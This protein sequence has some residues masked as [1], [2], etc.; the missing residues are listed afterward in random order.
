MYHS[1]K[2]FK[3]TIISL[4]ILALSVG[5]AYA[6]APKGPY[7]SYEPGEVVRSGELS[8]IGPPWNWR[9]TFRF[10][11]TETDIRLGGYLKADFIYDMDNDMGEV[12]N[13][14]LA[15]VTPRETDGKF[16]AHA[17]ESRINIGTSTATD[18]GQL[19]T[20]FESHFLGRPGLGEGE[21]NQ[22]R[23]AYMEL[24][25]V[26]AG[27]TWSNVMSFIGSP[28]IVKL[29]SPTGGTFRRT[30]Q[31]RYSMKPAKSHQLTLSLEDHDVKLVNAS[32][33]PTPRD[34]IGIDG[35]SSAPA[36]TARYE[37]GRRFA[38][39]GMVRE[40]DVESSGIDDSAFSWGGYAQFAQPLWQSAKLKTALWVGEGIGFY[41]SPSTTDG[42]VEGGKVEPIK[43]A[44]GY[45]ALEQKWS[46]R[47]SS[48]F[49][50]SRVQRSDVPDSLAAIER[51]RVDVAWANIFFDIVP[52]VS[53]G[54]EYI[55]ARSER[56]DGR[57]G[58]ANRIN[59]MM[60]TQF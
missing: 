24:G 28:R 41:M 32:G 30:T 5:A 29:G 23:H 54:L 8:R 59:A 39:A 3:K 10:P 7:P 56:F 6:Q 46:P 22:L 16:S 14:F 40:L 50:Y 26:L 4:P 17:L 27:R 48:T 18:Y 15:D 45:L 13:P 1:I 37:F 11:G 51:R 34:D 2:A 49:A 42:Y 52:R 12:T 20:Y 43:H 36:L 9:P 19:N 44:S 38:L 60:M 58:N 21:L 53:L 35:N 25:P 57:D 47:L 55:H 31:L 33:N